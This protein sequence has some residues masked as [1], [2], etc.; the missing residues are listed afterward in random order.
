MLD[1]GSGGNPSYVK[2]LPTNIEYIKSDYIEKNGVKNVVDFNKTLPFDDESMDTIFL[3]HNIYIA[4]DIHKTLFEVKR[5]LKPEGVVLISSPFGMNVMAEPH[6]Y[7][8]YTKE[9]LHRL[10]GEFFKI[11]KVAMLGDR[12]SVSANSFHAFFLIWPIRI[13]INTLALFFDK[14]IPKGMKKNHPFPIGYF[15]VARK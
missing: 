12:F 14:L 3:F 8:R 6:D 10:V 5:I 13:I 9:G 1:I 11:E 15:Y 7:V 2:Y 4:E